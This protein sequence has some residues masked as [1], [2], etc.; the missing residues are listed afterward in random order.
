M[1]NEC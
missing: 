1:P